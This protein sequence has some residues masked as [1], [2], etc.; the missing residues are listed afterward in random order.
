[1]RCCGM[2]RKRERKKERKNNRKRKLRKNGMKEVGHKA[3]RPETKKTK[4]GRNE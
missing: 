2:K 1:M 4:E 3:K